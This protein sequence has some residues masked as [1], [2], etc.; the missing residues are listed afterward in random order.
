MIRFLGAF[1]LAVCAEEPSLLQSRPPSALAHEIIEL[2][3]AA[4]HHFNPAAPQTCGGLRAEEVLPRRFRCQLRTAGA[5]PILA[6][7]CDDAKTFCRQERFQVAVRGLSKAAARLSPVQSPPKGGK[8]APEG[9]IDNDPAEALSLAKKTGRLLFIDFYG[10]WCPPCNELEEHAYPDPAFQAAAADFVKIGLDADAQASFDW[11]ARF[12]VGGYPTLIVADA[13]LR[14]LGRI[15]GSRSGPAL[16]RFLREAKGAK[17]ESSEK[18][19]LREA[20]RRASRGEFDEAASILSALAGPEARRELLLARRERARRE[21]DAPAGLAATRQLAAE[22]ADSA[23]FSDWALALVEADKAAGAAL[24]TPLRH[25]VESWLDSPT[26][27]ES[28]YAPGDLISNEAAFFETLGST[29]EAKALWSRA[30]DAYAAQAAKSPLKVPR[31][32]NF[33]RAE[34]LKNAGRRAEAEALYA[35]LTAAYPEEFTFNYDYASAL[36]DDGRAADAYPLSVKAER[37]AY[38]D[39]W[40]RAVR[41]KAELELQLGRAPEAAAT[42]DEALAQ[43]AMPKSTAVRTGRYL[44]ALRRL[45]EKIAAARSP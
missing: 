19:R 36:K 27:G 3:P 18:R 43:V 37:G 9:F 41:L 5:V 25:S 15:V 12:K 28:G 34:A 22:F 24:V 31:A 14:E 16:A 4:G 35:S 20:R 10:I 11:K 38:G 8:Q 30:A 44:I 13:E 39:N 45:R 33:G 17:D 32:A 2:K 21:E 1:A 42:V 6:S 7:I 40:L 23:E 29:Q 26:L